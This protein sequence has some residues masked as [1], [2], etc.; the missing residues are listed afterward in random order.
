MKEK[1]PAQIHEHLQW[2]Y[3]QPDYYTNRRKANKKYYSKAINQEKKRAYMKEYAKRPEVVA[4]RIKKYQENYHKKPRIKRDKKAYVKM[5]NSL[6]CTKVKRH[7]WYLNKKIKDYEKEK[8][9]NL[10]AQNAER[11]TNV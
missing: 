1:T 3:R 8:N 4:K 7:E 9:E 5:Y 11:F 10:H 2:V 6:F